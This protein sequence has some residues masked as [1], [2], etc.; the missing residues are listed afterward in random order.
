M[1]LSRDIVIVNEFTFKDPATG[2]GTRGS[3]PGNYLSGYMARADAVEQLDPIRKTD[4]DDFIT[5]YM[6]R[7]SAS[8]ELVVDD[9]SQ[10]EKALD[11]VTYKNSAYKDTKNTYQSAY[12]NTTLS[13]HF[14]THAVGNALHHHTHTGF[15][16][17]AFGDGDISLSHDKLKDLSEY[18]QQLFDDGKTVLKTVLSFDHDYLRDQGVI[19][20][21]MAPPQRGGYFG[22]VDQ[23]KLRT[24]ISRSVSRMGSRYFDDLHYAGVIQVDTEHVHCHLV[25]VDAGEGRTTQKG[26]QKG[27]LSQSMM[28]MLRRSVDN[29]L[30]S[31]QHNRYLSSAAHYERSNVV[32]YTK[33]WAYDTL[34]RES[35]AQFLLACLPDDTKL[36]RAGTNNMSMRKANQLAKH[37]V[38]ERLQHPDSPLPNALSA[39][40]NYA[41]RR[42]QREGLNSAERQKL[43]DNGYSTLID[44]CINGVY[45]VLQTI[46]YY[47]RTTHTQHLDTLSLDYDSLLDA[48]GE[49]INT[50]GST[51]QGSFEE[52]SVRMRSYS[53]RLDYHTRKYNE[54]SYLIDQWDFDYARHKAVEGSRAMRD[55]YTTE[56]SYHGQCRSKYQHLIGDLY[57]SDD[58]E[59]EDKLLEEWKDIDNYAT[60]LQGLKALLKDK[61]LPKMKSYDR[62]EKLGFELYGQYGAGGLTYTGSK[63]KAA[64]NRLERRVETMEAN[65]KASI[66]EFHNKWRERGKTIMPSYEWHMRRGDTE[67]EEEDDEVLSLPRKERPR[68]YGSD[69]GVEEDDAD[70]S[71]SNISGTDS[72]SVV[73]TLDAKLV[74]GRQLEHDFADVRGIDM[75]DMH[76]DWLDDKPVSAQVTGQFA[77]MIVRRTEALNIAVEWLDITDQRDQAQSLIDPVVRDIERMQQ[78]YYSVVDSGVLTSDFV[79]RLK[80]QQKVNQHKEQQRQQIQQAQQLDDFI[81]RDGDGID[82]REETTD[83]FT[84][85]KPDEGVQRHSTPVRRARTYPLDR[86]VTSHIN[87]TVDEQARTY[88][89]GE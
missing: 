42:A 72:Q 19:P 87:D 18:I 75:H 23:L 5:R 10:L 61:S 4:T 38:E 78:T 64:K 81:D 11:K 54:Y 22:H 12:Q 39:I 30:D 15:G 50:T 28:S 57:Y 36:W 33:K 73:Y 88:V 24:S 43:I 1:A 41:N 56:R 60:R 47:E 17:V 6:A 74:V 51:Q 3:T 58:T 68:W 45:T 71:V 21:D 2:S 63:K 40:E 27:K 48:L 53:A 55:F 69:S 89:P 82:D 66:D 34:S 26:V 44:R 86:Q 14:S 8:E 83:T 32:N 29:S 79:Q 85:V 65:Y 49:H 52:F 70:T 9:Y 7:S 37:M 80:A 25:L 67:E 20:E 59:S 46:P 13:P 35:S 77:D 84:Q 16:G 62:A 76:F 31:L